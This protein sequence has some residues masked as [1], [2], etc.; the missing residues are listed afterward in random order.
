VL[1]A[2]VEVHASLYHTIGVADLR[3]VYSDMSPLYSGSFRSTDSEAMNKIGKL[4]RD[5]P[6]LGRE[7][8]SKKHIYVDGLNVR[9][10][11]ED[12]GHLILYNVRK[13]IIPA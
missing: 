12:L 1:K 11:V 7:M 10:I 4:L 9:K 8:A 5:E 6:T 13:S 3:A 2:G